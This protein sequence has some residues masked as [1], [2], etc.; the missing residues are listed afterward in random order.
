MLFSGCIIEPLYHQE[1][2]RETVTTSVIREGPP[3]FISPSFSTKLASIVVDE[4]LDRFGQ[5]VRNRILFLIYEKGGGPIVPVYKLSLKTSVSGELSLWG[6]GEL[7]MEKMKQGLAMEAMKQG[8]VG[9]MRGQASYVLEDKVRNL[10]VARGTVKTSAQY[11]HFF[12]NHGTQQ[13]E[14]D[15]K[16]RVAE[17]LAEQIFMQLSRELARF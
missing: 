14:S 2:V 6:G 1:I 12:Q 13:S 3:I 4:P 15:A 8:P 5:M 7:T 9:I 17:E 11:R 16:K 10:V